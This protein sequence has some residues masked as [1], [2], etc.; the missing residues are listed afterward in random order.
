MLKYTRTLDCSLVRCLPRCFPWQYC[1]TVSK[2]PTNHPKGC[3]LTWREPLEKLLPIRLKIIVSCERSCYSAREYEIRELIPGPYQ[4]LHWS[5]YFKKLV[6]NP[7][8]F[9]FVCRV[10]LH[11]IIVFGHRSQMHFFNTFCQFWVFV[12]W[13][14]WRSC[15]SRSG[16]K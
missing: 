11:Q 13:E 4:G 5:C 2:S 1:K 6:T 8:S 3:E 12:F 7:N 15:L 16:L 14:S 9:P 10:F